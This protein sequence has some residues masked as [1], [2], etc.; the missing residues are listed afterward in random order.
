MT[1]QVYTTAATAVR[2]FRR[3]HAALAEGLS[4]SEIRA[5]FIVAGEDGFTIE[6]P[7]KKKT[8]TLKGVPVLRRSVEPQGATN[9]VREFFAQY[10]EEH[11]TA[12]RKACIAAAVEEG[13]AYFT[14]R[15]QYQRFHAGH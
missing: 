9:A 1:K 12:T 5:R 2:G 8:Q 10:V 13:F 15:T 14:A 11:P 4:T 3:A 6:I 7:A